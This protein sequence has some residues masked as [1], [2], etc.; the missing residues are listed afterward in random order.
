LHYALLSLP[1]AL[2]ILGDDGASCHTYKAYNNVDCQHNVRI[3]VCT[4]NNSYF[5]TS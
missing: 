1:D 2:A 5:D 3:V 4:V